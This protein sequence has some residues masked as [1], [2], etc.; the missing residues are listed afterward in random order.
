M[1]CG[2]LG[3]LVE[4][5]IG[6]LGLVG[7][8]N[9]TGWDGASAALELVQHA[10][11]VVQQLKDLDEL[12]RCNFGKPIIGYE[13]G[14]LH[15]AKRVGEKDAQLVDH[16]DRPEH[17]GL[18]GLVALLEVRPHGGRQ[19][20]HGEGAGHDEHGGSVGVLEGHVTDKLCLN[21]GADIREVG[22]EVVHGVDGRSH[23][24]SGL[25]LGE[26]LL[27]FT[28]ELFGFAIIR[29]YAIISSLG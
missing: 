15:M 1:A 22:A 5:R 21:D 18:V 12:V 2:A 19:D 17:Q 13:E 28:E 9:W 23:C 25:D 20:L 14:V 26:V 4:L 29:G 10:D 8:E 6:G 16:L 7:L 3:G 27:G 11:T 24:D